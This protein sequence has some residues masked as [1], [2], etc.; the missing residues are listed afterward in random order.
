MSIPIIAFLNPNSHVEQTTLVYHLAWMYTDL[1]L[2]VVAADLNP[3]ADLTATFLDEERLEELWLDQTHAQTVYGSMRPLL[4]GVG[5]ITTP[6]LEYIEEIQPALFYSSFA[7]LIGDPALSRCEDLFSTMWSQCLKKDI[8]AF[9]VTSAFWQVVHMAATSH[10]ADLVLIDLGPHLGAL[11]R[12]ALLA[13]DYV[14]TPLAPNFFPLELRNLGPTLQNWRSEWQKRLTIWHTLQ[15]KG[16]LSDIQLP[17]GNIQHIGYSVLEP[18]TRLDR[19]FKP[20]NWWISQIPP[21]YHQAV[22]GEDSMHN[23]STIHDD[24]CCLALLKPYRSLVL[25][26]QEARKPMFHLKPADGV[27]GTHTHLVQ[28]VYKNFRQLARN[29]AERIDLTIPTR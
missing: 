27:I 4:Q 24:P 19:P 23:R 15:K 12:A 7:L 2:R 11:N 21:E 9:Q 29:I 3:Q 10:H 18:I 14:I 20:Y 17:S 13:A 5:D 1:G 26:A 16:P 22:F 28:E 6:H 8:H 25:Y